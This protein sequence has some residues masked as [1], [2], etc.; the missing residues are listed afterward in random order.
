MSAQD[1]HTQEEDQRA[2]YEAPT[3]SVIATVTDA[4]LGVLEIN[5]D[6]GGG[7]AT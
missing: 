4:T 7:F 3:I 5:A 6:G 2:S 1:T